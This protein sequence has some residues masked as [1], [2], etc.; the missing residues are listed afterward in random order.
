MY[1]AEKPLI[2][3]DD[4][5]DNDGIISVNYFE[6]NGY[7]FEKSNSKSYPRKDLIVWK[8]V[9]ADSEISVFYIRKNHSYVVIFG[10]KLN[11][12][13]VYK[14]KTTSFSYNCGEQIR[15]GMYSCSNILGFSLNIFFYNIFSRET[16][17]KLENLNKIINDH[18]EILKSFE[19]LIE[20][21]DILE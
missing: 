4:Y 15:A 5:N 11:L 6:Y 8:T 2:I 20:I 1:T 3:T 12:I 19:P 9:V 16:L 7:L 10:N 18:I 14:V 13:D 17:L 21:K